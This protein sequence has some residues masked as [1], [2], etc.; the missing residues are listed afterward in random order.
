MDN[1]TGR[2]RGVGTIYPDSVC[3]VNQL[4]R[5]IIGWCLLM[6]LHCPFGSLVLNTSDRQFHRKYFYPIRVPTIL[7]S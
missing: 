7:I 3:N 6:L 2:L 5:A 4:T 1:Q